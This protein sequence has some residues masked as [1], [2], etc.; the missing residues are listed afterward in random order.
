[1]KICILMVTSHKEVWVEDA[2]EQLSQ[3][4]S[5]FLEFEILS[6]KG[7]KLERE[8]QQKKRDEDSSILLKSIR[9]Q[10]YVIL[11]DEKGKSFNSLEFSQ[12]L[13][14]TLELGK[15]RIVF[16]I[17]G[18]Y[19]V[20][21]EAKSR[22]NL[23]ICLSSLTLNHLVARVVLLEQIYRAVMIWKGRPYHNE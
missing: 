2:S 11:C 5:H 10:D 6:L 8:D 23:T 17:G 18:P 3:K 19:G 14:K 1:M 12:Q 16:V 9:P 20:N 7:R 21:S 4:I 13:V 22:A 15:S